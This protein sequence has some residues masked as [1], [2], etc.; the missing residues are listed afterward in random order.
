MW[1][2]HT[3]GREKQSPGLPPQLQALLQHASCLLPAVNHTPFTEAKCP[4]AS[5]AAKKQVYPP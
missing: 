2:G 4:R 5:A 3:Q 1:R